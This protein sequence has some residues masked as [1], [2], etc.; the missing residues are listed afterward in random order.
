MKREWEKV[1]ERGEYE[2]DTR[3]PARRPPFPLFPSHSGLNIRPARALKNRPGTRESAAATRS[4]SRIL[5]GHSVWC[6]DRSHFC[7]IRFTLSLYLFFYGFSDHRDDDIIYYNIVRWPPF[8]TV[9]ARTL[10]ARWRRRAANR[11]HWRNFRLGKTRTNSTG[12]ATR[13]R[14]ELPPHRVHAILY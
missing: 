5:L 3:R 6:A 9:T 2:I 14:R 10:R 12:W 7:R 4:P 11:R 13:K 1:R 8:P